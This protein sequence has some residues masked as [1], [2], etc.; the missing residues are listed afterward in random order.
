MALLPCAALVLV[1]HEGMGRLGLW[2]AVS[3][4]ALQLNALAMR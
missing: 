2:V 3:P 4:Y 1:C